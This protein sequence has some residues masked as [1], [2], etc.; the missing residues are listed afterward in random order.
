MEDH[1]RFASLA[2]AY[3]AFQECI[4]SLPDGLYLS[5]MNGDG[6]SPRDVVAHL[7]GWNRRMIESG[8]DILR[9]EQPSYYSDSA[10]D[11]RNINA[12]FVAKYSTRDRA[13]L[14][15][16]LA[17][18]MQEFETFLHGLKPSELTADHGVVHYGGSP[19]TVARLMDS[20]A[21][22]YRD[23]ARE[24]TEWLATKGHRIP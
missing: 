16:E 22:D 20:L 5:P 14:L 4:Q 21:G 11:Y 6:W 12:G 24:I 2:A 23:H 19:A 1:D 13:S 7:V 18:S 8:R 10:N 9:G 15:G 3:H 17:A